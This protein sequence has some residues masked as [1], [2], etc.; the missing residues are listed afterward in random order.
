MWTFVNSD[1]STQLAFPSK[2]GFPSLGHHC[3]NDHCF[4]K[5]FS[6]SCHHYFHSNSPHI[7]YCFHFFVLHSCFL[8]VW[9]GSQPSFP[10]FSGYSSQVKAQKQYKFSSQ[11]WSFL[12]LWSHW[13]SMRLL[14]ASI[15]RERHPACTVYVT[16]GWMALKERVEFRIWFIEVVFCFPAGL[17]YA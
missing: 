8:E 13:S 12:M 16:Y 6:S 14:D 11:S 5:L 1:S 4:I 9:N 2:A 10:L 17:T 7:T 15:G 3:L